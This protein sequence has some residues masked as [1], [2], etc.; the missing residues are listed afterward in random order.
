MNTFERLLELQQIHHTQH[1]TSERDRR[2]KVTIEDLA[3][4]I[5]YPPTLLSDQP[6]AFRVF[7]KWA[8]LILG[9]R[10]YTGKSVTEFE[11]AN[12]PTTTLGLQ[13]LCFHHIL[14]SFIYNILPEYI[15]DQAV[16]LVL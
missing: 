16:Q 3:C 12:S 15:L 10:Q 6:L 14:Y 2:S 5:C 7:L 11:L 8:R 1:L 4:I 9:V 13:K